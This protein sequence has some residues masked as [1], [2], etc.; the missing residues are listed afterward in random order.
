MK[1]ILNHRYYGL[2]AI[3]FGALVF[4]T[5]HLASMT[6]N[7]RSYHLGAD[8][9]FY[10]RFGVDVTHGAGGLS[11]DFQIMDPLYGYLLGILFTVTGKSMFLVYLI[12]ILIDTCTV[13]L[14][15]LIGKE[16]GYRRAG[17]IAAALY[18]ITATAIFYSTTILKPTLV[19]FYFA[20]WCY[21]SLRLI[22][23]N[24]RWCWLGYGLLLGIGVALRSNLLLFAL[25]GLFFVPLS[26]HLSEKTTK[27]D[28]LAQTLLVLA[29]LLIILFSLASRNA[30]ISNHWSFL[31]PNGGVV[32]HQIYNEENPTGH[33]NVPSFVTSQ[34]PAQILRDYHREAE[35]RL[36]KELNPF[37]VS[38]YWKNEAILYV[39]ESPLQTLK[40]ILRK[41][42][43][44]TSYKETANNRALNEGEFFSSVLSN[45]PRPFG[46]LLALG[47]PGL[48]LLTIRS[49]KGWILLSAFG[50]ALATFIFFFAV[51]RFRF[52][53]TP[54][55]AV[56]AG[57]TIDSILRWG[58]WKIVHRALLLTAILSLAGISTA[59]S[60]LV[61]E[62]QIEHFILGWGWGYTK[63]G[64]LQTAEFHS[65]KLL[66][67]EPDNYQAWELAGYLALKRNEPKLAADRYR[68]AL[69]L[70]S[71]SH[72]L[73]FNY[74]I[75]QENLGQEEIALNAINTALSQSKLPEYLFKKA[76]LL[77][78]LNRHNES[79]AILQQLAQSSAVHKT[80]DWRLYAQKARDRLDNL[81]K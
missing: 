60:S 13:V 21:F 77:G 48:V 44:F 23:I 38:S 30:L 12:Q 53:I 34:L 71:N 28:Y 11:T 52:P 72:T 33:H 42:L 36:G 80:N 65:N 10:I 29:G 54:I 62:P 41:T 40:N 2:L 76:T 31:P 45:L 1:I 3:A 14:T 39:M 22:H 66:Q 81:S 61:K 17:L 20:L 69:K 75:A 68:Q 5:L 15:Y 46:I 16:L 18:G 64:E 58:R 8:E 4:R 56:G 74:A 9:D 43:E 35:L 67:L 50:I 78:S 73:W 32:L 79:W 57:I 27:K 55:L 63:M 37:E 6:S 49:G 24:S 25:I 47:L 70:H 26:N 51:S 19:S 59:S 7:P